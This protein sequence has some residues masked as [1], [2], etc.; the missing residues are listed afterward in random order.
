MSS[1]L[2]NLRT[3]RARRAATYVLPAAFALLGASGV[4]VKP[5]L[6]MRDL[7]HEIEAARARAVTCRTEREQAQAFEAAGGLRVVEAAITAVAGLLPERM[8]RIDVHA[9]TTLC[10]RRRGLRLDRVEVGDPQES[11]LPDVVDRVQLVPIELRGSGSLEHVARVADDLRAAG[12]PVAVR[13]FSLTRTKPSETTFEFRL[14]LVLHQRSPLD[15][16]AREQKDV[17]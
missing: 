4:T 3:G 9:L 11:G 15:E 8:S 12:L 10:A 13:E 2:D 16:A 7:R 1:S 5:V 17:P 14:S 6:G